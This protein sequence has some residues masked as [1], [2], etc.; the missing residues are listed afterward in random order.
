MTERR[1]RSEAETDTKET[2]N[3]NKETEQDTLILEVE[4]I[5]TIED[6]MHTGLITDVK[7]RNEPYGYID[8]IIKEKKSGAELKMGYPD[9]ITERTV[10]GKFLAKMGVKLNVGIK[11]DLYR[12]LIER[13]VTFMTE[14]E[15]TEK[16]VFA[17]VIGGTIKPI[18]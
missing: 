3:K 13:E 17:R 18:N 6:G 2:Q 14:N 10:L 5:T 7:H 4:P 1:N 8:V 15:E 12:E 16:G 11:V 9:K